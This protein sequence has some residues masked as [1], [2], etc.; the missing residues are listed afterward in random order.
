MV[1]TTTMSKEQQFQHIIA[2]NKGIL[3]KVAR[4]Y[5]KDNTDRQDLIQEMMI[6]IWLSMHKY[7]NKFKYS[8]WLYRICMN[9]AIS[10][11]RRNTTKQNRQ[12]T[13]RSNIVFAEEDEDVLEKERQLLLLEQFIEELDEFDKALMLLYLENKSHADIGEILGLSVS[14]VGTKIARIKGKLKQKFSKLNS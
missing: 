13:L 7:D 11:Y 1:F 14:N 9:V 12:T 6:Q 4:T 2:E 5:C 8:T 3:L 10:F